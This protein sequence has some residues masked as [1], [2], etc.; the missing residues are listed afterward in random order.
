MVNNLQKAM[1][2]LTANN[3]ENLKRFIE[4]ILDIPHVTRET[5]VSNRTVYKVLEIIEPEAVKTRKNNIEKR[6][7]NEITRIIDA[8]EQGIPYEYLNY[9]K[10]ELFGYSSKFLT[11]DD[12]D[13]IK[14]RI[15]NLL[16]SYNPEST[17]TFYKLDYLTKAVRRIEMLQEIEKGKT[18][19][20]VA[21]EFNIHSPTLYRVQKQ[22]V[23]SS[24]YLPEVTTEQNSI[25]I[26]NMKIF[27]DFKN[28]HTINK[29]SKVYKIDRGLVETI[30]KVMKDVE[31]RINNHK[32]NGGKNNEFK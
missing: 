22:Y 5:G 20:A 1:D 31:I 6:R 30:I 7:K 13:K 12:E 2:Y 9:G 14:N 16:R 17:Y 11:M 4:G 25:I 29:I 26:R 18:I 3:R 8:V 32:D 24:K 23:E 10:A 28:N 21:K 27:E 15:Q 19:F